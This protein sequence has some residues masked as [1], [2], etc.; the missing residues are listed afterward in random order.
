MFQ[1][2]GD[3]FRG[4]GGGDRQAQPGG[5]C[6]VQ[7]TLDA[8]PHRDATLGCK[9]HIVAGLGFVELGH[10]LVEIIRLSI[11]R[12]KVVDIVF[13][14]LLAAGNREQFAVEGDIPMPVEAGILEG[15]VECGAVSVT[16][17]IGKGAVDVE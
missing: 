12:S 5:P 17:G 15:L 13:H 3:I 2:Y 11:V 8:G 4:G 14:P 6:L 1:Q 16:F 9:R 7:Q 10:Q